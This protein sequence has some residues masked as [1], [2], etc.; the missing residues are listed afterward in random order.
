MGRGQEG[1]W[2]EVDMLLVFPTQAPGPN[3]HCGHL[4]QVASHHP[5]VPSHISPTHNTD[6]CTHTLHDLG[7]HPPTHPPTHPHNSC[8]ILRPPSPPPPHLVPLCP[9]APHLVQRVAQEF[10]VVGATVQAG[11][12]GTLLE[13]VTATA[14]ACTFMLQRV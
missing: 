2:Y 9:P 7:T 4:P 5:L 6:S 12:D 8:P 3:L 10:L 1:N 13:Q 14:T 11:G